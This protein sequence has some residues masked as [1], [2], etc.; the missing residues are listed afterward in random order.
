MSSD[1]ARRRAHIKAILFD[2][3][4]TLIDF[5]R[6]WGPI[7]RAIAAA[8]ARGD[9]EKANHF[10]HIAGMD[11]ESGKTRADSLFASGNA[12]EIASRWI[13]DGADFDLD[14]LTAIIDRT[15][16]AAANSGV[17]VT[18]LAGLF[19]GLREKG[20]KLGIASSD[21]EDAIHQTAETFGIAD[22]LDFIAGY[23]S[24]Y[25]YKPE[26]GM[27]L[28]FADATGLAPRHIAMVGDNIHDMQM[29][30][31]AGAGLVI[32][33]LTGTGTRETLGPHADLILENIADLATLFEP[34][35][36]A[37]Q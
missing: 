31:E 5:D 16:V 13:T 7:N 27:V 6:S 14:E 29:G 32:G 35:A 34:E 9:V 3:D 18:D 20:F 26:P 17:A 15:S 12:R 24:G 8:A 25:G 21:A 22:K 10:L 4:G 2:K 37:L 19:E 1:G 23:D 11:T 30:I 33:V 36:E 28:G